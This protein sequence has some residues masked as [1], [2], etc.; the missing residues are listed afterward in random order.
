MVKDRPVQARRESRVKLDCEDL[1][2][3]NG[4]SGTTGRC[5]MTQAEVFV[6]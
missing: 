6:P 5:V 1:Q 4:R 3:R 2:H